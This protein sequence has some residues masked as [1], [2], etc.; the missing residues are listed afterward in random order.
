[1]LQSFVKINTIQVNF[2]KFQHCFSLHYI[3]NKICIRNTK[4]NKYLIFFYLNLHCE[5][6]LNTTFFIKFY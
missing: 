4:S 6:N 3:L 5:L 1:M 2:E